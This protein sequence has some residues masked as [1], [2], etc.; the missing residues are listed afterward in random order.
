M[1]R[2]LSI[3]LFALFASMTSFAVAQKPVVPGT[4]TLIN[5]VADDFEDP[6]WQYIPRD[7]KSTEDIDEDQRAPMGKSTNGRWYEG[8]KRG[9]PDIVKRVET[10]PGGLAGSEGALLLQTKNSGIPGRPSGTMHQDDFVCNV[11]YRLNKRININQIP[12]VTTRVYLPLL[13]NGRSEPGHI[14]GS[15]LRWK[16]RQSKSLRVSLRPK[17]PR[18]RSIGP[19]CSLSLKA[20]LR[21]KKKV[22]MR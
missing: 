15:V 21:R 11:Q 13:I 1:K 10:P 22:T 20:K 6:N 16:P 12:S 9:H 8:I 14:L 3:T 17:V 5:G 19:G 7:P 4:G 2:S 18:T